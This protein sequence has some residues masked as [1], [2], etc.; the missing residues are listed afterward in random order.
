MIIRGNCKEWESWTNIKFPEGGKPII[1]GALNPVEIN[2]E[3]DD[4]L[5]VESNVRL[6]H[7]LA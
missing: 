4:S 2:V 7:N 5:W 3:K 1:P 6:I